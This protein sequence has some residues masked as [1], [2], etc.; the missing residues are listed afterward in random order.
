MQSKMVT[1]MISTN[2]EVVTA[3]HEQYSR[4]EAYCNAQTRLRNAL[5]EDE[6]TTALYSHTLETLVQHMQTTVQRVQSDLKQLQTMRLGHARLQPLLLDHVERSRRILKTIYNSGGRFHTNGIPDGKDD[7]E[8][9]TVALACLKA[10]IAQI[11]RKIGK[12]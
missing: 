1:T 12:K 11:E 2:D 4:V 8:T 3:L 5:M 6:R 7:I 10:S 9:K